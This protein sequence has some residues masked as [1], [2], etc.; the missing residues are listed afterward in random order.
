VWKELEIVDANFDT[1]VAVGYLNGVD[2]TQS[3]TA[4]QKRL[5]GK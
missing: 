1:Q 5:L 3:A 4:V 2:I